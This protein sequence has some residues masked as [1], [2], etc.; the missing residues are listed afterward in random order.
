MENDDLK[1]RPDI[2]QYYIDKHKSIF[3]MDASRQDT[4]AINWFRQQVGKYMRVRPARV[5]AAEGYKKRQSTSAKGTIVGKLYFF[6]YEAQLPGDKETGLYDQYPMIFIFNTSVTKDN[7]RVLYGLNMHYLTPK[8]RQLFYLQLLKLRTNPKLTPNS[9]IKMSWELIKRV[10]SSKYY[11][12]AVH[13][14][15]ADRFQSKMIEIPADDWS[16]AVFLNL[17]RWQKAPLAKNKTP[18]TQSHAQRTIT[19]RR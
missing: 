12:K 10:A 16:I 13:A 4:I 7:K 9:R 15:R 11:E 6:K 18:Y 3:G 5:F 14:Y 1:L 19:R 2:V 8:D 17:Q